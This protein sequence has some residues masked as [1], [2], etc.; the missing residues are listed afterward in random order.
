MHSL[1]SAHESQG[2]GNS[3]TRSEIIDLFI[4]RATPVERRQ[5]RQ[6]LEQMSKQEL[7]EA[8]EILQTRSKIQ[9]KEE[10]ILQI[11]AERAAERALNQHYIRQAREPQ[12][13]AE[14]KAQLEQDRK[15]FTEAARTLRSFAVNEANFNVIRQ[16]LGAGF[17]VYQIQQMLAANG[18]T[19]SPPTQAE[20]DGWER[21]AIEEHNLRLRSADIPT[22]RKLAREAG[23]RGPATPALDETQR[24]RAAERNDGIAYPPLPEEFRVGGREEVLDASFIKKCSR[25]TL[26]LLIKRY[27][28]TQV[29]EAL[30]TRVA[31]NSW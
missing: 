22:L 28:S 3:M 7:E 6:Q 10:Q 26:R 30:R 2:K 20:L 23:A 9:A 8:Y 15:T 27:G 16:T 24:V 31:G 11:Q 1:A 12:R 13:L 14:E 25:E 29:T 21:R 5:L 4:V 19:L 17:S 18:E